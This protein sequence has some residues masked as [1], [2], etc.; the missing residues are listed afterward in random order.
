MMTRR[1]RGAS[2]SRCG[3][4]HGR[5]SCGRGQNYNGAETVAKSGLCAALGNN[6]FN[7]GHR[8]A[9]DQLRTSWEKPVQFVGTNYGHNLSNE[10]QNKI[11]VIHPKPVHTPEDLARHAR[12]DGSKQ[13]REPTMGP[14]IEASH[15][16]S[17][18]CTW[19][20]R[21]GKSPDDKKLC[22]LN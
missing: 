17:F 20:I 2:H 9:V 21:E 3:S 18:S 8:A 19:S 15:P 16:R 14:H 13:R 6:V 11:P 1:G 7:Y 12:T 4:K 5:C 10:L 22:I